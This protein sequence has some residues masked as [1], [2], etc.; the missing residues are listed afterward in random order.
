M[1]VVNQHGGVRKNQGGRPRGTSPNWKKQFNT[2]IKKRD[3]S[4]AL[5]VLRIQMEEKGSIAAAKYILDQ[6]YGKATATTVLAGDKNSPVQGAF[7]VTVVYG[8]GKKE[9]KT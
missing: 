7:N 9:T 1:A 6:M 5:K 8:D 4:A 2:L 3:I